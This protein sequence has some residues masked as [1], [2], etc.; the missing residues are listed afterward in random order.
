MRAVS[1]CKRATGNAVSCAA[2]STISFVIDSIFAAIVRRNA[3]RS[4]PEVR[5]YTSKALAASWTARSISSAVAGMKAGSNCLPVVGS[6][7]Y[8]GS[9]EPRPSLKPIS[10]RPESFVIVPN[11][12]FTSYSAMHTN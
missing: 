12:K 7:A 10:E 4:R 3:P 1:P 9:P 8:K 2:R 11:I 5:L 6:H